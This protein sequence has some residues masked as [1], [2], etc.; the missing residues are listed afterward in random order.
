MSAAGGISPLNIT[1]AMRRPAGPLPI[2]GRARLVAGLNGVLNRRLALV[3][4]PGGY[5]KTTLL[6]ELEHA[7][8][9]VPFAWCSLEP[10]GGSLPAFLR[11][12]GQAV[13]PY[14]PEGSHIAA[15]NRESSL[16]AEIREL[17]LDFAA[18]L[19]EQADD[20]LIIV[21]DDL[22]FADDTPAVWSFL[23]ALVA[24]LPVGVHILAASRTRPHLPLARLHSRGDL[25]QITAADL[26]FTE[27]EIRGYF[28][29]LVGLDLS[30][31]ELQLI[32]RRTE[33][34]ATGLVLVA[35]AGRTR[36]PQE[37]LALLRNLTHSR[38]LFEYMAQ[39]VFRVQPPQMQDFLLRTSVLGVLDPALVHALL[40]GVPVAH[41]LEQ[42]EGRNLFLVIDTQS[43]H[44]R[45]HHL[46]R[47]FLSNLALRHFGIPVLTGLHRQAAAAAR[48]LHRPDWALYHLQAAEDWAGAAPIMAAL[49][50][51]YL[52]G[53][54]QEEVH[55]WL[56]K[57]PRPLLETDADIVY[58][59]LQLANWL[60]QFEVAPDLFERCLDLYAAAGNREGLIRTLN[61]LQHHYYKVRRPF[62]ARVAREC[63]QSADP[64]IA[65]RGKQLLAAGLIAE[66][67]W[68][69]AIQAL[70]ELVPQAPANSSA[71]WNCQENLA[72]ISFLAAD[73][74]RCL[75]HGVAEIA[76][77]NAAGSFAWGIYNW[78]SYCFLGDT[79]GMELYQ[80]QFAEMEV[81]PA[82]R[83]LFGVVTQ[84]GQALVH[85]M[86]REWAEAAGLL[87][88]LRPY[89]NDGRAFNPTLGADS[90]YLVRAELARIYQRQGRSDEA[91][92]LLERNLGL[93]VGYTELAALTCAQSAEHHAARG[94][95]TQA[96]L[97]LA[98]ARQA[99]PP[100]VTGLAALSVGLAAAR[101]HWA[102]GDTGQATAAVAG[103]LTEVLAKGCPYLVVHFGAEPLVPILALLA[104]DPPQRPLVARWVAALGAE[105]GRFLGALTRHPDPAMVKAATA[106]LAMAAPTAAGISRPAPE[107]RIYALG[108]C[109]AYVHDHPVGGPDWNRAKVK[110]LLMGL[111]VRKGWT[112]TREAVL[113]WL[114]PQADP[115]SGR[116]NLRVTLHG[117]RRALEPELASG[118]ESRYVATAGDE[119]S[120]ADRSRVWFDL[121]EF[122]DR[123]ARSRQARRNGRRDEEVVLLREAVDLWHGPLLPGPVF[124]GYLNE[125][126]AR[127]D[128]QYIRAC[129][130]LAQD[131]LEQGEARAAIE[132]ARKALLADSATE[133]AYQ[134]LIRAHLAR[135][136]REAALRTWKVCRKYLRQHLG[137]E[138][139]PETSGLLK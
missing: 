81:V 91:G 89:H 88:G 108:R 9:P 84:M 55:L 3:M 56:Q 122:E 102:G 17:A 34:W 95:L 118:A 103:V 139:A 86:K 7:L 79:V 137:V 57:I 16:D 48:Q 8:S 116:T 87:E 94:D 31:E 47:G 65:V 53:L 22:H 115:T 66:G 125:R 30:N 61:S 50:D 41:L 42:L 11:A 24:A 19:A 123:I 132:M 58:V 74:R 51:S 62:V 127:V 78:A 109:E 60:N 77:R 138:P 92:E 133:A 126:R 14:L 107:L 59:R 73:F 105:A 124:A 28:Q 15:L 10:G 70:E 111:L 130:H 64:E 93:M 136:D 101:V 75:Q 25:L 49:V 52:R 36:S 4:A 18:D 20:H 26:H 68:Q 67:R 83:R 135:G 69:H 35:N 99:L 33:G 120:L 72:L 38:D 21:L 2:T 5:G 13:A 85:I 6:R 80:R 37:R 112:L 131:A 97:L 29:D 76:A 113:E 134:I 45:Y 121:W 128:Q 117:L 32:L 12:L 96:H 39:E 104:Q 106:L 40:P 23:D 114:W 110:L 90:T 1:T 63:S 54:R 119:I 43:G 46:F 82:A 27:A 98:R 100:G 129:L 44:Y 71:R